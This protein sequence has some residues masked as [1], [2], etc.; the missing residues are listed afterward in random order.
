M[1]GSG[2]GGRDGG[3]LA[4][5]VWPDAIGVVRVIVAREK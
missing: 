4:E 5:Q 3:L 2:G 1:G